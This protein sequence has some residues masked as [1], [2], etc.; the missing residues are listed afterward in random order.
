MIDDPLHKTIPFLTK[1]EYTRIIGMRAKQIDNGA[2]IFVNPPKNIISGYNIALIE[3][4]E[5]KLPFI[6]RRPIPGGGS[7]YWHVKDLEYIR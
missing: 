4:E 2:E 1:Y 5:N 3:L 6:I 7:E